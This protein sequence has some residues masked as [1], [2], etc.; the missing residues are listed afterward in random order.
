MA[1]DGAGNFTRIYNWVNDKNAAIKIT[2]SRMDGE[3]DGIATALNQVV[4]RSGVVAYTGNLNMGNNSIYNLADGVVGTPALRFNTDSA[5]G[6]YLAASGRPSLVASGVSRLEAMS[7]GVKVYGLLDLGAI[8]NANEGGEIKFRGATNATVDFEVD[9]NVDNLRVFTTD[10]GLLTTPVQRFAISKTGKL[11]TF[12]TSG[13]SQSNIGTAANYIEILSTD[14]GAFN[15]KH[16]GSNSTVY[17]IGTAMNIP[18]DIYTNN[19]QVVRI[20]ASGNVA[21]GS[22]GGDFSRTWRGVF[23]KAQNATTQVGVGN[24]TSGASAIAQFSAFGSVANSFYDDALND[25]SGSPFHSINHGSS[26]TDWRVNFN[27]TTHLKLTSAGVLTDNAGNEYGYKDIPQVSHS[28]GSLTAA[29]THRNKHIYCTGTASDYTVPANATVAFPVG[30]TIV[31]V[32]DIG[33]NMTITQAASVTLMWSP[34]AAT[35]TRT[36]ANGGSATLLKL[37]TNKWLISGGGLT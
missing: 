3:F 17:N 19:A 25:N 33:G 35:G 23:T 10:K 29:L 37:A 28:A 31:V 8:D 26:V 7:A 11:S 18:M 2:A 4:L 20:D 24:T 9:Q 22:T 16:T 21:V 14:S 12:G 34:S 32:N 36:L 1:Y 5:S 13:S 6:L 15:D 30:S 27:G